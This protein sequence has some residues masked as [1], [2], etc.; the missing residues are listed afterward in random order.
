MRDSTTETSKLNFSVF[1]IIRYDQLAQD[2]NFK[3]AVLKEISEL[4][5]IE[6]EPMVREYIEGLS[7]VSIARFAWSPI[8]SANLG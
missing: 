8:Q 2:D 7:I 3:K 1:P 4:D 5:K 6:F